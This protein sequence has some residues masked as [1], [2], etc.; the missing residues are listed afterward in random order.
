V[1]RVVDRTVHQVPLATCKWQRL[2]G[3]LIIILQLIQT[4]L[5][6][7]LLTING[8]STGMIIVIIVSSKSGA[9]LGIG[10]NL[11]V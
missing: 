7:H 4:V 10:I 1:R 11:G 9:V 5:C 2:L 3:K 6:G 8:L